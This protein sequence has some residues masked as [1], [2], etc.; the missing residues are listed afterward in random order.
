MVWKMTKDMATLVFALVILAILL[1][2]SCFFWVGS[3]YF[4][5][6]TYSR[7][8]GKQVTTWDAMWI[9][10]RVIEPAETDD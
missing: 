7:L 8:T 4:E 3:S 10:L 1:F 2:G 6:R 5:A 9:E